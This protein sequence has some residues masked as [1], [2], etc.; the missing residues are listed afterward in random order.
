VTGAPA[1]APYWIDLITHNAE[2]AINSAVA[3]NRRNRGHAERDNVVYFVRSLGLRD[4]P[5]ARR[6]LLRGRAEGEP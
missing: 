5:A 3:G 1:C 2:H 6:F 4:F